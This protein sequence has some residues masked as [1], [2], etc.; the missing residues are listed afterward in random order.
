VG[1]E[2]K[3]V[4]IE[5]PDSDWDQGGFLLKNVGVRC[6]VATQGGACTVTKCDQER[7]RGGNCSQ[8]EY[9]PNNVGVRC[10]VATPSGCRVVA[11]P[12]SL[13]TDC[14]TTNQMYG[15]KFMEMMGYIMGCS[16]FSKEPNKDKTEQQS[17]GSVPL[18]D[19][20]GNVVDHSPKSRGLMSPSG[21]PPP[22]GSVPLPGLTGH[23]SNGSVTVSVGGSQGSHGSHPPN[24]TN[25]GSGPHNGN[26]SYAPGGSRTVFNSDMDSPPTPVPPPAPGSSH[27]HRPV[28]LNSVK[29]GHHPSVNE[30]VNPLSIDPNE[31]ISTPGMNGHQDSYDSMQESLGVTDIGVIPPPP[32]FSSPSPPPPR[33]ILPPSS[34]SQQHMSTSVTSAVP[35]DL[36][37]NHFS[38]KAFEDDDDED[39]SDGEDDDDFGEIHPGVHVSSRQVTTVP[40]KEPSADAMPLKSAL[41]KTRSRD[42]SNSPP[43][44][45]QQ[46]SLPTR[47]RHPQFAE[48]R[49]KENIPHSDDD[50]DGPILYRDDEEE[51]E[52]RLADK[53]AR[54]ESLSIKLQQRP[55]QQDLIDKNIL[56][57]MSE[58]ERRLD[59]SIIGAKL[60]RRLSLRPTAEELEEKNILKKT[61]S[62][63]LRK[64]REE[65][66]RY[67]LRKLS[68]RPTIDE[69]KNK[70]II[71]FND[72][73]EVTPCHE[74]DRRADKPWTRLTPKDKAS[75]R[76][77]LNDFKSSEM[78]V[79]DESRHL[80]RFHRP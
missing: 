50:E 2:E 33:H 8:G 9:I 19:P 54:K 7:E 51:E 11:T 78:A 30:A 56:F 13:D 67:L 44:R 29:G 23:R 48:Y 28:S 12:P 21:P 42:T 62:D 40:A 36:S 20:G 37:E 14:G 72:Y 34:H 53:L 17:N 47:A 70:K 79:H 55:T 64:E 6:L 74:Y 3:N 65:K 10:L 32:M 60:I 76:K 75:I 26:H 25:G 1:R 58:E 49:D 39:A 63:E 18:G 15:N 22:H 45:Q 16:C 68:F 27:H 24:G 59:R 52:D 41:K 5:S 66:K 43:T 77:E 46:S 31:R 38:G 71:K 80:T 35:H 57:Q 61:S 69:L 4:R 73:I